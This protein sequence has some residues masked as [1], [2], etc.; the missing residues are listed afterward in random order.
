MTNNF[1][2]ETQTLLLEAQIN[3]T[4]CS[5]FG[6]FVAEIKKIE[7]R[8]PDYKRDYEDFKQWLQENNITFC[9]TKIPHQSFNESRVLQDNNFY[10]M[11]V[12][13]KPYLT[14]G[15]QNYMIPPEIHIELASQNDLPDLYNI[16]SHSF[17][18]ERF[19]KDP[20]I[21]TALANQRYNFFLKQSIENKNQAV[22]KF[23]YAD[24]I[25][26]FFSVLYDSAHQS[27]HWLLTALHQ[28]YH[29]KG[30]GK[31]IWNT[32]IQFHIDQ[33]RLKKITTSISSQNIVVLNLYASLGFRFESPTIV[34]HWVKSGT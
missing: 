25:I 2:L 32:M 3:E 8:S 31:K 23:I 17:K 21:G 26:G 30:L 12:N 15:T 14:I 10:F 9:N 5:I 24:K 20:S 19:H 6:F 4:D 28:D 13:Y 33:D 27:A 34:Y 22:Y 1:S 7:I 29:S 16:I 18:Y 11:E